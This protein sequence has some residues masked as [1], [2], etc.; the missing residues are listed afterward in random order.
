MSLAECPDCR[1]PVSDL[2]ASCPGCGRMFQLPGVDAVE[3]M[4]RRL[5]DVEQAV[6]R[7]EREIREFKGERASL[8]GTPDLPP[9]GGSGKIG[10][11]ARGT[12]GPARGES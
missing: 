10:Y 2:A 4:A 1:R 3:D 11:M 9:P 7:H 8:G 12:L 5:Y 6:I